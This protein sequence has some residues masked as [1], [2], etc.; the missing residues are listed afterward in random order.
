MSINVSRLNDRE[1]SLRSYLGAN[2]RGYELVNHMW[3]T[4]DDSWQCNILHKPTGTKLQAYIRIDSGSIT[5]RWVDPEVKK[6]CH[7]HDAAIER[8]ER[9]ARHANECKGEWFSVVRLY[10]KAATEGKPHEFKHG[11]GPCGRNVVFLK[12]EDLGSKLK[13]YQ[14]CDDETRPDVFVYRT[15]ELIRWSLY[16]TD[17][18]NPAKG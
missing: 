2:F 16:E 6:V 11:L 18:P 9:R 8:K 1:F 17:N 15:D 10:L 5:I 12:V 4:M 7:E 13:V 3:S 14:Y